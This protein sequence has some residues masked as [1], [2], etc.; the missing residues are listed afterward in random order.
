MPEQ[1]LDRVFK[2]VL[3]QAGKA[4]AVSATLG[5]IMAAP[6]D[7]EGIKSKYGDDGLKE[8]LE[9]ALELIDRNTRAVDLIAL[10]DESTIGVVSVDRNP[11]GPKALGEK[12]KKLLEEAQFVR[13]GLPIQVDFAVSATWDKPEDPQGVQNLLEEARQ[14]LNE[15]LKGSSRFKAKVQK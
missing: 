7:P 3:Q 5:V 2:R 12:I 10:F 13:M 14:L 6:V 4:T 15:A 1:E 9:Q 11:K 8:I